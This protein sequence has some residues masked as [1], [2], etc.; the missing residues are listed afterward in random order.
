ML[1][2]AEVE[3]SDYESYPNASDSDDDS[4]P[5]LEPQH[6]EDAE[7]YPD[8][9]EIKK[10]PCWDDLPDLM[11]A[12]PTSKDLKWTGDF[13]PNIKF[14]TTWEEFLTSGPILADLVQ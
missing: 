12:I 3:G 1:N 11:D 4:M 6:D 10:T 9:E 8:L 2:P 7:G 5:D 14:C 13:P